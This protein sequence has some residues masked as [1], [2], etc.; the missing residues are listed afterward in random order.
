MYVHPVIQAERD[1]RAR[2][3]RMILVAL[4]ILIVLCLCAAGFA[5]GYS[6]ATLA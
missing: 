2:R 4:V 3:A 5:A 6:L 1:A